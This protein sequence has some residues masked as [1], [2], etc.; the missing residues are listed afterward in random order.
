MRECNPHFLTAFSQTQKRAVI[1]QRSPKLPA[2]E[3][4]EKSNKRIT[5]SQLDDRARYGAF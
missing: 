4:N 5:R 1:C 3:I 2:P